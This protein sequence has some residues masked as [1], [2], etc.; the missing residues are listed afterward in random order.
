[1]DKIGYGRGEKWTVPGPDE[2][3]QIRCSFLSFSASPY[4][5]L[6]S[7]DNSLGADKGPLT[8][9]DHS[10]TLYDHYY[11][12]IT[13]STVFY[14]NSDKPRISFHYLLFFINDF[15]NLYI[16]FF[17]YRE[18]NK[19]TVFSVKVALSILCAGKLIDKFR[20]KLYG[21]SW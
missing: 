8:G 4:R 18:A 3:S 2:F 21:L 6:W 19:I 20:C 15:F 1:M 16:L 9:N 13:L 5:T 11:S 12:D 17:L 14:L 10:V 7:A